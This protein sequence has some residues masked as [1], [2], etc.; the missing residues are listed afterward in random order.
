MLKHRLICFVIS[1]LVRTLDIIRASLGLQP[2]SRCVVLN[3][4]GV[5]PTERRQFANQMDTLIRTAKPIRA[6]VPR[7]PDDDANYV[8]VTFDDGLESL[9]ENAIPELKLRGIPSAIFVVTEIM[10]GYANWKDMGASDAVGQ[11]AMS[12]RQLQRLSDELIIIGSH[13]MTHPVL[14]SVDKV[15]LQRELAGSR[16][17]LEEILERNVR[18]FSCPYGACDSSVVKGCRE[19]GYDRVFTG[20]PESAF[21]DPNEFV[22]GR[23]RTTPVDWPLEFRLKVAGAYRWLPKAIAWKGTLVSLIRKPRVVPTWNVTE[24]DPRSANFEK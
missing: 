19:A 21:L 4:H 17:R 23:V 5:K 7:L 9:L 10:G 20:L 24:R 8:V 6:D 14:P 22:T 12:E 11:K 18:L 2:H 3:Y 16:L 15:T 13:S 1:L